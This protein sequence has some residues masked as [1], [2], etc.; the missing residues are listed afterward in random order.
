MGG[1]GADFICFVIGMPIGQE[2]KW[3]VSE[4]EFRRAARE[5]IKNRAD[6]GAEVKDV[7]K[8]LKQ[9]ATEVKQAWNGGGRDVAVFERGHE[10][11]LVTGGMSYGDDPTDLFAHIQDLY[12][13]GLI[14]VLGFDQQPDDGFTEKL[15]SLLKRVEK[16]GMKKEAQEIRTIFHQM[17]A[18]MLFR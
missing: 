5:W 14:D 2:P 4:K 7:V 1:T 13:S 18:W 12:D 11:L 3:G 6:A 9:S 15:D 10:K 17:A 16:N 8:D